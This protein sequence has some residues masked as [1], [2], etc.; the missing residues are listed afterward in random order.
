MQEQRS[1]GMT[2]CTLANAVKRRVDEQVGS[3]VQGETTRTQGWVIGFIADN[4]DRDI[5]QRDIEAKFGIRRSTAT[6]ILQLM[7]KNG[8]LTREAVGYD[9]RLKKLT[10]T[11]KALDIHN[12]VRSTIMR[13]EEE[14]LACLTPEEQDEF[15]MLADKLLAAVGTIDESK[16]GELSQNDKE[17]GGKRS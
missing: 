1:L 3:C 6:G 14:M 8:L 15:F 13:N 4:A 5:F 12:A 11:P 10:L 7:E 16:K 9:A 17:T 2:V